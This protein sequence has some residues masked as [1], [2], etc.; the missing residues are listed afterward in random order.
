MTLS[1]LVLVCA[2][3]PASSALADDMLFF[4][5]PTGNIA[6]MVATGEF[7]GARCDLLELTK[8]FRKPP[9]DCELEWGSSF[10]VDAQGKGYVG[11]VGDAV[12]SPDAFTLDYGKS[13]TLGAFTCTSETTGM[14]CTN[15]QGHGFSVAKA[16]Q[17]VF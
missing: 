5:S 6:C 2:L 11:C 13:I 8:T 4:R 7:A 1:R 3:I 9:A 12:V 17:R 10:S 14:T 16:K 15:G